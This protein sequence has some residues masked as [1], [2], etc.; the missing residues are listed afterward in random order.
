MVR[1]AKNTHRAA[2]D[3]SH[4]VQLTWATPSEVRDPF[5]VSLNLKGKRDRYFIAVQPAPAPHRAHPKGFAALHKGN[6]DARLELC[7]AFWEHLKD[8]YL[9][10]GRNR[11]NTSSVL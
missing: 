8:T 4:Q 1:S 11:L 6:E 7:E 10:L 5:L 9:C 2:V 3:Q